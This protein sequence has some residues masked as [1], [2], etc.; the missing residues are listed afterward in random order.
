[1][2]S[3]HRVGVVLLGHLTAVSAVVG[4]L[5]AE[6]GGDPVPVEYFPL[7]AATGEGVP[8]LVDALV[9]SGQ[10]V[11]V[12]APP[13]SRGVEAQELAQRTGAAIVV[14]EIGVSKVPGLTEAFDELELMGAIVP[15]AVVVPTLPAVSRGTASRTGA[16]SVAPEPV[17]QSRP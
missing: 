9:K 15:G 11:V 14:A 1:M 10:Y 2:K 4:E 8:A 13:V 12:E 3:R 7:S 5:D 17:S 6:A 16:E